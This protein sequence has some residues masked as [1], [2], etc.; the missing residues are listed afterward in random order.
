MSGDE[1]NPY[2]YDKEKSDR[3]LGDFLNTS[4]IDWGDELSLVWMCDE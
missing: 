4:F 3:I 2:C 1:S